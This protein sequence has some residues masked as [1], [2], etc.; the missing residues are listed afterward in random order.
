MKFGYAA[1]VLQVFYLTQLPGINNIDSLHTGAVL[2]S[3]T[4]LFSKFNFYC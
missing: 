3:E 1:T 2:S 4:R